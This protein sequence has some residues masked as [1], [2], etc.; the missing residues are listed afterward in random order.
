MAVQYSTEVPMTAMAVL[1]HVTIRHAAVTC[2]IRIMTHA[3]DQAILSGDQ[4]TDDPRR[5]CLFLP[6]QTGA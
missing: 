3:Q 2:I 6:P 4:V 5:A 1:V